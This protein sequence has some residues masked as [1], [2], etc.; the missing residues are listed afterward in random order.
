VQ[1]FLSLLLLWMIVHLPQRE[2]P[3]GAGFSKNGATVLSLREIVAR[4]RE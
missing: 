4:I 3:A 2:K 1:R